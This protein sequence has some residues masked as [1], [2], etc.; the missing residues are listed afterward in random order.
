MM[1]LSKD[2]C[3]ACIAPSIPATDTTKVVDISGKILCPGLIDIHTH[4][5]DGIAS[6]GVNPDLGGVRS[7]VTTLVDAGSS[8]SATF[9]G[10]PRHIIPNSH[11]EIIPFLHIAQTGLATTPDIITE[12][13]IDYEGTLRV[14]DKH[15]GLIKGIK[16]RMVSPALEIFGME[17]PKLAK[18]AAKE[19]GIKLMV[20]IGD[21]E[22]R[23]DGGVIKELLP[24]L[25]EGDIVTHY[26]TAN[27]GGVLDANKKLVPEARG[28]SG[29]GRLAGH[30]PRQDELQ[31]RCGP[32]VL[33]PRAASPLY[34]HRPND[35]RETGNSPQYDRDDDPVLGAGV[36]LGAG[37]NH[38]HHQPSESHRGRT[39]L[40][41]LGGR[42]AS[43]Y[44]RPA[45]YRRR[46]A[47]L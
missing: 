2:G 8:G 44:I 37:N 26:F 4:V 18:R 43:G 34:K 28:C 35:P 11:T 1:L 29:P 31:L 42:K 13:S 36:H 27:P 30:S 23:F 46:L 14:V 20:H 47:G 38:V 10:F 45:D 39:S 22:K 17:M 16:A 3:I 5:F 9:G 40:G 25:E 15:K 6:N 7:G 19:S 33:G 12:G 24:I 41:R 32:Q 21:T